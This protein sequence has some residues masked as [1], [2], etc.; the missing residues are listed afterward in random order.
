[1]PVPRRSCPAP[2]PEGRVSSVI[3][4]PPTGALVFVSAD[5]DGLELRTLAQACLLLVGRSR[6]AE[7]LN[8]GEDPHL[9][10]G[11]NMLGISYPE[12]CARHEQEIEARSAARDHFKA[13]GFPDAEAAVKAEENVPAPVDDARQA[14]KVANF[15]FPGGLGADKL[16]LFARKT[17]KVRLTVEKAKE[18]KATWLRTFPEFRAYFD[19]INGMMTPQGVTL[20]HLFSNRIRGGAPYCAACNSY[21]QGLGADATGNALFLISEAC[22]TE[23]PCRAC[24]LVL[25][26]GIRAADLFPDP[27]SWCAGTGVSPLF[28]TR[29]VNYIHDDFM[30]ETP[31]YK[32]HEVAF[33]LVRIM[34]EGMAPYLPDVPA[35]AKPKA[36]RYWSKVA[37]QVWIAD[38]NAP[39][40]PGKEGKRLV[41]WPKAA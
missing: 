30:I 35:T 26:G 4:V 37:K 2:A 5:V 21:F 6:L 14:G 11:A 16:I 13:Q 10:M 38:A 9:H 17:Y 15:G 39:A 23:T 28:G 1:V 27:C 34:K 32:A 22:Y 41:A 12:A 33:E 25:D 7:V 36:M 20:T 40:V 3:Q 18:L 31:E 19:R 24:N 8:S 29:L